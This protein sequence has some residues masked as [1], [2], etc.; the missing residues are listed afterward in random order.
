MW[1]CGV[2]GAEEKEWRK[3]R[4]P[5]VGQGVSASTKPS[6]ERKGGEAEGHS[7]K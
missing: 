5:E 7:T 2:G 3:S 6:S 1:G 4:G